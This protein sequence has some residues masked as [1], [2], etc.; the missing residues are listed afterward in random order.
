MKRFF[1]VFPF[2]FLVFPIFLFLNAADEDAI[3]KKKA[4]DDYRT[5]IIGTQ[6]STPE[7][8]GWT[9]NEK[10]CRAGKDS[11]ETYVKIIARINYYRR[12]AGVNDNMVLDSSWN[13]YAQA[14]ALIMYANQ[15]LNHHPDASMKCFSEDG[16]IGAST[17]NLS[18]FHG[19]S[20][21]AIIRDEIEDGGESNKDCGHRRWLLFSKAYKFGFGATPES[22]A[23]RDFATEE[24]KDT[25][26]FHGKV[27][28]YFGY[29]FKGFVPF[30]VVYPK[31]SFAITGTAD[32]T[33]ASVVAIAGDKPLV[34]S[35]ISRGKANYGDPTLIWNVNGIKEEFYYM[36]LVKE[37]NY[38][39]YYSMDEKRKAFVSLGLLNKKITVKISNVKVEGKMKSYSYSFTIIDPDEWK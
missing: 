38:Y 17:S 3:A 14:A 4:S 21:E 6:I 8:L 10:K 26:S 13:K 2:L 19:V 18:L 11:H 29:P 37:G 25:S 27:P 9:G 34:C 36:A 7:E 32:F 16:K 12:L 23:V 30:Q 28:E 20:M 35:I 1:S 31:W 24:E 33:N 5:N 22:Y 15:Q 39:Q